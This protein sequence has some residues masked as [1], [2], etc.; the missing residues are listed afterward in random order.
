VELMISPELQRRV[1]E[2]KEYLA[3]L[4]RELQ[5][6]LSEI[7]VSERAEKRIISTSLQLVFTKV[8][9]AKSNLEQILHEAG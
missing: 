2:A 6:A 5:T 4:E 7:N 8:A 3:T 1:T 9:A